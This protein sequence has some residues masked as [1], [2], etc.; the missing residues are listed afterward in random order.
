M[1]FFKKTLGISL[2]LLSFATAKAQ[3]PSDILGV[4]FTADARSKIEITERN[5]KYFG[6]I[7]W[8]D[9]PNDASGKPRKDLENPESSLRSKSIL[10][11]ENLKNFVWDKSDKRW[12]DGTIY[13]PRN[14]ETYACQITLKSDAKLEVRGYLG[15]PAFGRTEVWVKSK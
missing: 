2:F 14:G 12:E 6:S 5:G 8:I 1:D 13:D 10:G 9:Q 11:L 4:W 15:L 7:A 3:N